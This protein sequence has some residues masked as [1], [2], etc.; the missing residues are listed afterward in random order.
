MPQFTVEE[1]FWA[2]LPEASIGAIVVHGIDNGPDH[3]TTEDLLID[4]ADRVAAQLGETSPGSGET[5]LSEGR[6]G[7]AGEGSSVPKRR[8]G[9]EIGSLPEIAPW[10]AAYQSFG[11][12]PSKYKSS[13]ENMLRSVRAGR[14][15]GINPLVDLYNA[16]SLTH[17]LPCGGEDLAQ[18]QG[19]IR[20]TR[21]VGGEHFIPL[22]ADSQDPPFPGEVIYR[23]DIGAICRCWNWR[24]AE[25]TK[26]THE[27]TDVFLAIEALP[28]VS[29]EQLRV[30]V[31][32]LSNLIERHLG[33]HVIN[34]IMNR[35]SSKSFSL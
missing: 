10:R 5:P 27:T 12:K 19:D 24:E 28:P 21:A 23:D 11:A 2:L 30:A 6:S 14:I 9:E 8:E 17:R 4:V 7:A 20:L 16:V 25:R 22:G 34:Q 35:E 31:D 33:G 18:I 29:D 1:S 3:P 26:I 32:E 15:R 13:I